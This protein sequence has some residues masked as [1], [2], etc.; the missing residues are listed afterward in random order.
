MEL[1]A[2]APYTGNPLP[3]GQL[4]MSNCVRDTA[5][6]FYALPEYDGWLQG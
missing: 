2:T 4:A 6:D 3:V 5:F 1:A